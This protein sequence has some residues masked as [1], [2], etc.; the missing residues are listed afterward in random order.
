[1][2]ISGIGASV[3]VCV[4]GLLS[5]FS[6]GLNFTGCLTYENKIYYGCYVNIQATHLWAISRPVGRQQ[7]CG[8]SADLWAVS[9][10]VGRQQTCGP[11]A[12]L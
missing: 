7:T 5:K 3:C 11:S 1:M 8:P 9:R 2:V 10:P 6:Q 4:C 12:D